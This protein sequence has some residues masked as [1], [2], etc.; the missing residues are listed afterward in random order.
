MR[1]QTKVVSILFPNTKINLKNLKE[2]D[3]ISRRRNC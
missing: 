2:K 3:I 1:K